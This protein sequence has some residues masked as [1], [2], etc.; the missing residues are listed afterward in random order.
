MAGYI[1]TAT[2]SYRGALFVAAWVM[3]AGMLF[4]IALQRQAQP[5]K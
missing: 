3:A 4:L 5:E 1:A 2:G